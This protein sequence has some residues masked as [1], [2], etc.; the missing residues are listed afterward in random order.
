MPELSGEELMNLPA[1]RYLE[2]SNDTEVEPNVLNHITSFMGDTWSFY[3]PRRPRRPGWTYDPVTKIGYPPGRA[4]EIPYEE[5][6]KIFETVGP[7]R[8]E[9]K[10][11]GA[12][13]TDS[14]V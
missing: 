14:L 11:F 8:G 10:Q 9:V 3:Q 7:E 12:K 5:R 1:V 6:A 4:E 13:Y 2:W